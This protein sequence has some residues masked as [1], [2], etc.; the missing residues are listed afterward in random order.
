MRTFTATRGSLLR[1]GSLVVSFT[2]VD[3]NAGKKGCQLNGTFAGKAPYWVAPG[4]AM[5]AVWQVEP[6]QA[7][8]AWLEADI[9]IRE[10]SATASGSTLV[11]MDGTTVCRPHRRP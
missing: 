10:V 8:S 7:N 9:I 4:I 1:R 5:T 6:Y 11:R 3:G 2:R